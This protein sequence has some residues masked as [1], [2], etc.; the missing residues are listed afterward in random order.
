[1]AEL[2]EYSDFHLNGYTKHKSLDAYLVEIMEDRFGERFAA[3][4]KNWAALEKREY[5][6]DFPLLVG[7]ETIDNC[8]YA[9]RHCYRYT[10]KPTS[11]H[12]DLSTFKRIVDEGVEHDLPCL[13]FGGGSEPMLNKNIGEMIQYAVDGGVMDVM[14]GTNGSLLTKE[15]IDRAIDTGLT[16]LMISLDASTP[17]TYKKIRG[18]DLVHIEKMLRYAYEQREKKGLKLPIIRVS[19]VVRDDNKH[20]VDD[21]VDKWKEIADRIDLQSLIDFDN[22]DNLKDKQATGIVCPQPWNRVNIWST[23]DISPCC[24]FYG[25]HFPIGNIHKNTIKEC[26]DGKVIQMLR[27]SLVSGKYHKACTNCYGDL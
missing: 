26:W 23:G 22:V 17:E 7:V 24:T 5:I 18:G 11:A 3:Y 4:R 21:F 14:L 19:F 9:C 13:I 25:K 27:D 10:K 2:T 12:I 8:N 15:F 1:M 20:E 6:P 16:R